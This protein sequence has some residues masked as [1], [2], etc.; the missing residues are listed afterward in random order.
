[1][2]DDPD[3]NA[4]PKPV[5][6]GRLR[7]TIVAPP[8]GKRRAKGGPDATRP[9]STPTVRAPTAIPGVERK[10]IAVRAADL[11]RLSPGAAPQAASRAVRLID[12]FVVEGAREPHVDAWGQAAEQRHEALVREALDLSQAQVLSRA[13]GPID[14]IIVRLEAIDIDAVCADR[15]PALFSLLEAAGDRIDTPRKLAAARTELERLAG[16][17]RAVLDGLADLK[18]SLDDHARRVD[19]TSLELEAAALAALFLAERLAADRPELSRRF[20]QREI[21]LTKTVLRIRGGQLARADQVQEPLTLITLIQEVVLRD[22]SDWLVAVAAL[23]GSRQARG[24]LSS[25]EVAD[26][27]HRLR[28]LLRNLQA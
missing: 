26:L 1:M 28:A 13:R 20:L 11:V 7:P 25:T 17:A 18:A 10:R 4:D 14:G 8:A 6:P 2:T 19:E 22:L 9:A 15:R 16:Q 23:A 27:R 24:R 12:G 21:S 5:A 3:P